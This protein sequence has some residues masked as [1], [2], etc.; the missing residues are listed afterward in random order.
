MAIR[1]SPLLREAMRLLPEK[2]LYSVLGKS[3][4]QRGWQKAWSIHPSAYVGRLSKIDPTGSFMIGQ[5][6]YLDSSTQ[7]ISSDSSFSFVQDKCT[8]GDVIIGNNVKISKVVSLLPGMIIP[9]NTTISSNSELHQFLN[10]EKLFNSITI[11]ESRATPIF[12]LSTGRA[13]STSFAHAFNNFTGYQ[14]KHESIKA[15]TMLGYLKEHHLALFSKYKSSLENRLKYAAH[16]VGQDIWV[17]SD[18]RLY[19]LIPELH[20]LFPQAQFIHCVR[21]EASFIGSAVKR[22]WYESNDIHHIW[23]RFRPHPKVD[24][25][26]FSRWEEYT[27]EEKLSWYYHHNNNEIRAKLSRLIDSKNWIEVNLENPKKEKI[28]SEFVNQQFRLPKMN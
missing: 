4:Y 22:G 26:D 14:G 24:E 9:D 12:I 18:Q 17:E 1:T 7:L 13:G 5:N 25:K 27:Q 6:S 8:F 21:K 3:G 2:P 15:L 23:E 10:S 16:C 19:N 28:I 20:E 11:A